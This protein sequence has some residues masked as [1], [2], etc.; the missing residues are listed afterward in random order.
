MIKVNVIL[1]VKKGFVLNYN[2]NY[3]VLKSLYDVMDK[4]DVDFSKR[5]HD[6]KG[7]TLFNFNLYIDNAKYKDKIYVK[8]GFIN[9]TL[10]GKKEIINTM[11]KGIMKHGFDLENENLKAKDVQVVKEK[12]IKKVCLYNVRT[13]IV[14]TKN[15]KFINIYDT[16]EFFTNL[17]MNL[18]KK[19]RLVYKKD[20]EGELYFDIEDVFD[21]KKKI[22]NNV[23]G[24]KLVGYSNFNIYIEADEDMQRVAY[25]CGLGERNTMGCGNLKFIKSE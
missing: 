16:E 12:R 8:E 22:I 14:T 7:I 17:G 18:L 20:Y 19:Y 21:I 5:I 4:I 13:P 23:K 11:V 25:N 24:G 3:K 9:L 2:Y 10:S 15:S 6:D 1:D